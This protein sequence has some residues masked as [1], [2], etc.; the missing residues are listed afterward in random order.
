[1]AITDAEA[2]RQMAE[3]YPDL[4]E[5]RQIAFGQNYLQDLEQGK[6][7]SQYYTGFGLAPDWVTGAIGTPAAT[8]VVQ[9]PTAGDAQVAEQIAAQDR[10][11]EITGASVVQPTGG[12]QIN[13]DTP[14]TQM[15]TDPVTGQTQTV[16]QAMTSNAANTGNT[17]DPILASGAAGGARLP[18]DTSIMVEDLTQPGNVE[19]FQ[20]TGA[21]PLTNQTGTIK[22]RPVIEDF[23][24]PPTVEGS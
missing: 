18:T 10:D 23:T 1:M 17:S 19:D 6:G 24:N 5:S 16:K 11:A 13:V 22:E 4:H 15:I 21:S 20:I 9:E 2:A 14:L 7:T 8:P 12:E 3:Q